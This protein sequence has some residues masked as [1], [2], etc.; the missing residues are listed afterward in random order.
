MNAVC[1]HD[2]AVIEPALRRDV[3]LNI[4]GLGDLDELFWPH[5]TW[6]GWRPGEAVEAVVLLYSG[7]KVPTLLALAGE[8]LASLGELVRAILHLL[9]VR[10][11]CHLTAQVVPIVS[12]RYTLDSHGKYLKMGL[13]DRSQLHGVDT[14]GVI[15]LSETELGEMQQLYDESYEGHWFEPQM[16]ATG[17][18]V[19][20]R[21]A[22]RLVSIAG[23]HVHSPRYR[24]AALGNIATHPDYRGRGHARTLTGALCQRLCETTD[25]IGLNVK[26]DNVAAIR[27]YERLGFEVVAEYEE[28]MAELK[29][30]Q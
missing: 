4:Y 27:C 3:F 2:K 11:Y 30:P 24:V 5:T 25:H 10:F 16:L 17:Q 14:A 20:L 28:N 1:L 26:A 15:S 13:T 29:H 12:E 8:G 7:L 23:V 9:P 18:Y 19:G 6:Y 21:D 22:G